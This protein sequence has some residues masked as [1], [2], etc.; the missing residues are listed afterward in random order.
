MLKWGPN[1][2]RPPIWGREQIKLPRY[3]GPDITIISGEVA[4]LLESDNG[5]VFTVKVILHLAKV[6]NVDWK[7]HSA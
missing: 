7:L 2:T 4:P 1:S 5:L 6:L 3:S